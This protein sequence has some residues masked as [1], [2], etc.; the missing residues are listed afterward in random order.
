MASKIDLVL[1]EQIKTGKELAGVA[2]KQTD[3]SGRLFGENGQPGLIQYLA[4]KDAQLAKSLEAAA[5]EFK[6][7]IVAVKADITELKTEKRVSK[8]YAAGAVGLGTTIGYLIKAGLLR[9]GFHS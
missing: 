5:K 2:Q 4:D 6:D 1:A 7:A 9:I 3:M 8:A